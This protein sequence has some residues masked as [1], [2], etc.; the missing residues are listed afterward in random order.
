VALGFAGEVNRL[1]AEER[2]G[3]TAVIVEEVAGRIPVLVGVGSEATHT[4]VDLAAFAARAGA[5]GLVVVPPLTVTPNERALAEHLKRIADATPLPIVIQVSPAYSPAPVS[6]SLVAQVASG[7]SNVAYVKLEAGPEVIDSWVRE[8]PTSIGVFSGSGGLHLISTLRAGA[9][10]NMPG[11]E[12]ADLLV[13]VYRAEEGRRSDEADALF[14]RLLPY[15]VFG[16]VDDDFYNA[17]GKEVLIRRGV[18]IGPYLR[19][20]SI[21]LSPLALEMIEKQIGTLGISVEH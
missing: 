7:R 5:D 6:P 8:L 21:R 3:L 20:P 17:C 18:A 14:T 19:E 10:G 16:L 12:V 13:E 4:S 9:V 1:T 2:K 11:I 15:L